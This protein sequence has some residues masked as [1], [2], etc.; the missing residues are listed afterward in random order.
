MLAKV[1]T[2]LALSFSLSAAQ[3]QL[4]SHYD[5]KLPQGLVVR[6]EAPRTYRFT[7]EYNTGNT[8]GEIVRRQRLVGEYTRGLPG[9]EVIWRNVSES[10]A[11]GPTAEYAAPQK[12]PFME[13]FR[14]HNNFAN[15]MKP[16]FFKAFP[17]T[18]VFERNLV[19]DTQMFEYFGQ[20]FFDRLKINEPYV[21]IADQNAQMPDVGNFHN[22]RVVL[23]WIGYS[24]RNGQDC[25]I[26][27]YRAFMNPVEIAS[28][29][30]TL[31]GRS[32]YWGEIWV[33]LVT[34]QI[35]YGTLYENVMGEVKMQNSES[36]QPANIFRTATFE[37]VGAK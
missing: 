20:S 34:K 24:H 17:V 18:A 8:Q 16:E 11:D 13:G 22:K 10:D 3:G 14:Y 35:E 25:A 28:A 12:R 2:I 19:W 26:I 7:V 31:N 27:Q 5:W 37:P 30:I 32:D 33:S 21:A 6:N 15:S 9:E 1:T 23:E 36:V 4:S 29:G